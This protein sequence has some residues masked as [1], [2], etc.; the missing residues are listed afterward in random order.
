MDE[1][2]NW[3]PIHPN[4][5]LMLSLRSFPKQLGDLFHQSRMVMWV[6]VLSI[7]LPNARSESPSSLALCSNSVAYFSSTHTSNPPL[8]CGSQSVS[9]D[10]DPMPVTLP[11]KLCQL[12]MVLSG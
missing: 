6:G 5:T 7:S 12:R 4:A 8:V 3:L 1:P 10:S 2:F 11:S 9:N